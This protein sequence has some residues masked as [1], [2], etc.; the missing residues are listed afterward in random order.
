M[1]AFRAVF[2]YTTSDDPR[3]WCTA[4]YLET[5]PLIQAFDDGLNG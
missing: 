5:K 1:S 2:D 3:L 4:F